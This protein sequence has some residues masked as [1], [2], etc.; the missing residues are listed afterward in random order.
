MILARSSL[1][2][3]AV[4][5][6]GHQTPLSAVVFAGRS[7]RCKARNVRNVCGNPCASHMPFQPIDNT[8]VPRVMRGFSSKIPA[9]APVCARYTPE[10]GRFGPLERLSRPPDALAAAFMQG[11]CGGQMGQLRGY[12]RHDWISS[13][14]P[15]SADR[16][17][18]G[19][20]LPHGGMHGRPPGALRRHQ[21]YR[22][23]SAG[24]TRGLRLGCRGLEAASG[25]VHPVLSTPMLK[26]WRW[27][28]RR[29]ETWGAPGCR[30]AS[31]LPVRRRGGGIAPA[32][33]P[34]ASRHA[35]APVEA[36][37]LRGG[38]WRS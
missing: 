27:S 34:S 6:F 32:A 29:P 36:L 20:Q 26:I 35:V 5:S 13:A 12:R 23:G 7:I 21:G 17:S 9:L 19:W 14:W 25:F 1:R 15:L 16:I 37:G 22:K 18:F 33:E 3:G 10:S 4:R 2:Q 8:R 31:P 11:V 38:R 24:R 30:R 28:M